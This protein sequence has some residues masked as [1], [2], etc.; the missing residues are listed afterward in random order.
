MDTGRPALAD[1]L[2]GY[3]VHLTLR[4]PVN[5]QTFQ[6]PALSERQGGLD[7][8]ALDTLLDD[9][10]RIS[11]FADRGPDGRVRQLVHLALWLGRIPR[12]DLPVHAVSRGARF[13]F[14][15][16]SLHFRLLAAGVDADLLPPVVG[17]VHLGEDV[18]LEFARAAREEWLGHLKSWEDDPWLATLH[19]ADDRRFRREL[20]WLTETW[21]A[22]KHL[23]SERLALVPADA[24]KQERA[25]DHL[26][27]AA[28]V[29]ETHWLPR[30]SLLGAARAF[31]PRWRW[32]RWVPLALALPPTA[33]LAGFSLFG[34]ADLARYAAVAVLLALFAVAFLSNRRDSLLLLR[35]PAAVGVGAVALLSFTPRWWLAGSGWKV[36]AGLLAAA[37]LY[38]ALESR[39]H[40]ARGWSAVGRSLLLVLL[41]ALY[42]FVL[43]LAVLG[44]VAPAVAENGQC[45]AGWWTHWP[46]DPLPL[47]AACRHVLNAGHGAAPGGVLVLMS[48]WSLAVGLAAQILWDDRPVTAPLGRLR[49]VRGGQS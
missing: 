34:W 43:N 13:R 46:W 16:W 28:D 33:V 15:V 44:F 2:D 7:Y 14:L 47:N 26:R 4:S 18:V 5:R 37:W 8:L 3:L 19:A 10:T 45:L 9:P 35:L 40:S 41:G 30:S 29:A 32:T 38:L 21:P 48:G 27:V 1:I 24:T 39:L 25:Q 22:S 11:G 6:L 42:A 36:G 17:E 12:A 49:R 31:E 20:L 23:H